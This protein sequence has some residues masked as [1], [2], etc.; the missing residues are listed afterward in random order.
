LF[1][2]ELEYGARVTALSG[3]SAGVSVDAIVGKSKNM[4]GIQ[5]AYRQTR[6]FN[7]VHSIGLSVE[8][9]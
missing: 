1:S 6:L 8:I 2:S 5:Y 4:I 3:L 9:K 7:G